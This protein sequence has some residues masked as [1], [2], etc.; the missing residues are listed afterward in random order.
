MMIIF[1]AVLAAVCLV[2]CGCSRSNALDIHQ[3]SPDIAEISTGSGDSFQKAAVTTTLTTPAT[4]TTGTTTVTTS[5][6]AT[7]ASTKPLTP[8]T[9]VT[10]APET[11][12]YTIDEYEFNA[13]YDDFIGKTVFVG[14]SI[15]RGLEAY[16]II[17]RDRVIAAGSV[18]SYNIFSFT[19][20]CKDKEIPFYDALSELD[21]GYAVFSMGMNDVNTATPGK[22]AENYMKILEKA[23]ES[24]PGCKLVVVPITPIDAG[25]D[26]CSND[27]IDSYNKALKEAT[28]K[29]PFCFFD[30]IS[31]EFKDEN[32][33]LRA[34]L[35]GGDGIHLSRSAYTAYLYRIWH[36]VK[37]YENRDTQEN[38]ND[39]K[40]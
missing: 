15:C 2:L 20:T 33:G 27:R 8:T 35:N 40:N 6:T 3:D 25:S 18:S 26:F 5:V 19:F 1:Y 16:G 29:K 24:V 21:P 34:D 30:D 37:E 12:T 13:D 32:N 36:D 22:F 11:E 14:D 4:V 10:S 23:H 39:L 7:S 9:T 28:E 31:G 38:Q 17:P